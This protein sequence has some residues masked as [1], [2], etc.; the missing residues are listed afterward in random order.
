M[1]LALRQRCLLL[2]PLTCF[3]LRSFHAQEEKGPS[4]QAAGV[5]VVG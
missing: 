4:G 3:R 5:L 2:N 1:P